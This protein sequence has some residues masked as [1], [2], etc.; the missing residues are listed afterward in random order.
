MLLAIYA[1][2]MRTCILLNNVKDNWPSK[3]RHTRRN[4]TLTPYEILRYQSVKL[5]FVRPKPIEVL[6]KQ[7]KGK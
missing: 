6:Q 1:M 4:L 2:A 7:T 3:L 5:Y